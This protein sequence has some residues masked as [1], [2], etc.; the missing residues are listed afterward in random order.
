MR[1]AI[2]NKPTF[3]SVFL[4]SSDISSV[5]QLKPLFVSLSQIIFPNKYHH[6]KKG[7]QQLT[8][9]KDNETRI[10]YFKP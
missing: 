2:D 6:V 1:C 7:Q 10:Y 5:L 4:I 3:L 9:G 8:P